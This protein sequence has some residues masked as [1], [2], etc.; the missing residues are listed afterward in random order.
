MKLT[1]R[2]ILSFNESFFENGPSIV[3]LKLFA[4]LILTISPKSQ[5]VINFQ[6]YDSHLMF[7]LKLL[8]IGLFLQVTT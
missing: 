6:Y 7:F 8:G 1:L 4:F 5:K 3:N 2:T